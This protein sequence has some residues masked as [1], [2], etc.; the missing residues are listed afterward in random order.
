M[1]PGVKHSALFR[2]EAWVEAA[3]FW[4]GTR[5]TSPHDGPS[6]AGQ[7]VR[8]GSVTRERSG[9]AAD[10]TLQSVTGDGPPNY[11]AELKGSISGNRG[12]AFLTRVCC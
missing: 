7:R 10:G 11:E 6:A 12:E 5:F 9:V 1:E 4:E 2:Y 8:C 3:G